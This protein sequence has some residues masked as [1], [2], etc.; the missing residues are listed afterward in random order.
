[1][2]YP[3][4]LWCHRAG[5]N[6]NVPLIQEFLQLNENSEPDAIQGIGSNNEQPIRFG[7]GFHAVYSL[8]GKKN[9][10]QINCIKH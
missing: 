10:K 6:M 4:G 9:T 7:F 2:E 1:M 8:V 3:K 5:I